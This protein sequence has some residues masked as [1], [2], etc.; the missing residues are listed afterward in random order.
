MP[1]ALLSAIGARRDVAAI[2][3]GSLSVRLLL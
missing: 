3:I 1:V 2:E